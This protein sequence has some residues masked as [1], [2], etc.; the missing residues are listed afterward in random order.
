MSVTSTHLWREGWWLMAMLIWKRDR[1]GLNL[2]ALSSGPMF[3]NYRYRRLYF[4]LKREGERLECNQSTPGPSS[5]QPPSLNTCETHRIFFIRQGARLWFL[6]LK[7]S[8]VQGAPTR[9]HFYSIMQTKRAL[10]QPPDMTLT[11]LLRST[12]MSV[13]SELLK[14]LPAWSILQNIMDSTE[15]RALL[16]WFILFQVDLKLLKDRGPTICFL[17]NP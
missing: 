11:Y 9:G 4:F 6:F 2:Y 17:G 8:W 1:S 12:F 7:G 15:P 3:F 5:L 13:L 10:L 14:A 16:L